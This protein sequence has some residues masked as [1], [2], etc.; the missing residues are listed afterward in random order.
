GVKTITITYGT[1]DSVDSVA[2]WYINYLTSN[3]WQIMMEQSVE[4]GKTFFCIKEGATL[5][6]T[7]SAKTYTEIEVLYQG[8]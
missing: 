5:Q 4:E 3:N 1:Y 8:A 7:I 2:S 6:L